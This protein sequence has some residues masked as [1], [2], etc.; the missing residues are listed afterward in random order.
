V[1][2]HLTT[3]SVVKNQEVLWMSL[4]IMWCTGQLSSLCGDQLKVNHYKKQFVWIISLHW[5][6]RSHS[7]WT[8]LMKSFWNSMVNR[9]SREREIH[10][11]NKR[12]AFW[13]K[14]EYCSRWDQDFHWHNLTT[15]NSIEKKL[16]FIANYFKH[17]PYRHVRIS[18]S[19][20]IV[21]HLQKFHIEQSDSKMTYTRKLIVWYLVEYLDDQIWK[22]ENDD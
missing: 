16:K 20:R 1:V 18:H 13:T 10:E 11:Q 14:W 4:K 12:T 17:L 9:S 19:V 3:A 8:V 21:M 15:S 5:H 22:R 2:L 6:I 7:P